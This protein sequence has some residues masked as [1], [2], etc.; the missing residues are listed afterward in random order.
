M[1]AMMMQ[2]SAVAKVL[3]GVWTKWLLPMGPGISP[4]RAYMVAM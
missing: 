1:T 3:Y 4:D 2:S